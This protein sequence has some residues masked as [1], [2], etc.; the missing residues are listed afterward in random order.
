MPHL[1]MTQEEASNF[2]RQTGRTFTRKRTVVQSR[3]PAPGEKVTLNGQTVEVD[4]LTHVIV[5][6][7]KSTWCVK[8]DVFSETYSPTEDGDGWVKTGEVRAAQ[9]LSSGFLQTLEGDIPLRAGDVVVT[10]PGGDSYSMSEARF[11]E[12]YELKA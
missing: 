12:L 5:S 3:P 11:Q 2:T 4:P 8:K 9:V 6:D 10:N 1:I 7:G